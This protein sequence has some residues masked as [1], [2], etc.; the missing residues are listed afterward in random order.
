MM[1]DGE[2]T[3]FRFYP[4]AG[5]PD[6]PSIGAI[7]EDD[8]GNLWVSTTAGITRVDPVNGQTK[9]YTAKDGLIDGSYF[10]GAGLRGANGQLHFG[11]ISGMTSFQPAA[12]RDNPFPPTVAITDLLVLNK[13]RSI[14]DLATR[15]EITLSHRDTVF[16]LEFA[17]LH[18]A[19]PQGN[20]YAYRLEGF[21]QGWGDTDASRRFAT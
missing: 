15:R 3:W 14:P 4:F 19:D 2:R 20:R 8:D 9:S 18:Y 11:G 1:R 12:V 21:D 5:T 7:L 13:T 6:A 10:V 17:A 16:T